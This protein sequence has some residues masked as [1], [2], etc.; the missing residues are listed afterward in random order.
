MPSKNPPSNG[1]TGADHL[2]DLG[3]LNIGY[4]AELME[5]YQSNPS[6]VPQ[7]DRSIISGKPATGA[8]MNGHTSGNGHHAR[9]GATLPSALDAE[10]FDRLNRY[11]DAV[12]DFG[13]RAAHIDPLGMS[14]TAERLML[15]GTHGVTQA[16]LNVPASAVATLSRYPRPLPSDATAGDIIAELKETYCGTT[17]YEFAHVRSETERHWLRTQVETRET[18]FL[19]DQQKRYLLDLLSRA[20]T[21]E[22]FLHRAYPGQRWYSLEGL[23]S[24]I[25]LLDQL[26]LYSSHADID[27]IVLGMAHR[28]RLNVLAHT[29]DKPYG[30]IIAGFAEGHFTQLATLEASGWL[31]DVKYH[32]GARLDRDTDGDGST[33]IRLQM[34]PNP[35]HL[36]MVDPVV[37]GVV[38]AMQ[39]A[40]GSPTASMGIIVHGDAAFAGQGVVAETFNLSQ[41]PAY[42]TGG[43][44]HV[45][46]NNQ[47]GF[48]TEPPDGFSTEHP[49][50]VARGYDVPIVHVNADDIEACVAAAKLAIAYR[51]KFGKDFLIDLVG[52]RRFGHNENDEPGFTQ[53]LM[54]RKIEKHPTVR[55]IWAKSVVEDGTVPAEEAEAMTVEFN[56]RLLATKQKIDSELAEK[57]SVPPD[58]GLSMTRFRGL[59]HADSAVPL[60][61]LKRINQH[62]NTPPQGF[63]P[64][65]TIT[66]LLSRRS[67]A[68]D[69]GVSHID[70]GH[71][72]ALALGSI[73]NDGHDIRLTGQ[74]VRRG[75][76]SHRHAALIDYET[77]IPWVALDRYGKSRFWINNSPLSEVAT[78]SFEQGYS[79]A[80]ARSLV[81]W[82]AQ[83]GDFVNNAQSVIDEMIVSARDK[84]NQESGLVMLLPHGYEGQGPNHSH[85]HIERF[86]AL[87]AKNNIRIAYPTTAAQYFHLLR[88][89]AAMLEEQPLP[90]IVMTGKSLLRHPLAATNARQ[91]SSG[92]FKPVIRYQKPGMK[93]EDVTRVVLCTGKVFVDVVSHPDFESAENLSIIRFE[94]LYPFPAQQLERELKKLPSASEYIWLQEEPQNRGAWSFMRPRLLRS[95]PEGTSIKYVGRPATPSPAEGSHWLHKLQQEHL[96]KVVIGTEEAISTFV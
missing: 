62:I 1:E 90:L 50:D 71:A 52:Y 51:Q 43:S 40:A 75:T 83:F 12:R 21:F 61:D 15:P 49:S 84:W 46:A 81:I 20:E 16:D 57:P 92:G 63:T 93:L 32:Q 85:A 25:V 82:E 54:Y 74:D 94:E 35:S 30:D 73:L 23:E 47:I 78:V 6:T 64:H 8:H 96:A 29:F 42:R 3:G 38:R 18:V 56:D 31:T 87:A 39:D 19:S 70:W 44:I 11:A 13:Y 59:A 60:D 37:V 33:N 68:L 9:V 5:Q 27:N 14:Q 36:E 2:R 55:E 76:F 79:V 86:L 7:S 41:L 34:L 10:T 24:L 22:R 89:Q 4:V 65:P 28:G 45:I 66:R 80:S 53:P 17:G 69:N 95:L 48:T 67:T 72:E 91:L 77:G 26:I 58:L 88:S